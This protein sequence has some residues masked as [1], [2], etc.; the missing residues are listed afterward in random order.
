MFTVTPRTEVA[1]SEITLDK[2]EQYNLAYD[3]ANYFH[4]DV[5][6]WE[7][8]NQEFKVYAEFFQ[9]NF[10]LSRLVTKEGKLA[11]RIS[12]FY[13]TNYDIVLPDTVMTGIGNIVAHHSP[14][15]FIYDVT[16]TFDW[17]AGDFGDKGSCFWGNRSEAKHIIADA[18]GLALR[19]FNDNGTGNG[20]CWLMPKDDKWV[21]F[22]AYG[23][24]LEL[25]GTRIGF[26]FPEA[27]V[28]R[29]DLENFGETGGTLYINN[30]GLLVSNYEVGHMWDSIDLEAGYN[31]RS[32]CD[33]CG[34]YYDD[35]G[36]YVAYIDSTICRSCRQDYR[37]CQFCNE[38]HHNSTVNHV[39]LRYRSGIWLSADSYLCDGCLEEAH[40]CDDCERYISSYYDPTTVQGGREVCPVC[41]RRYIKCNE[42]NEYHM[43]G[44]K[45]ECQGEDEEAVVAET[46]YDKLIAKLREMNVYR[47]YDE[48]NY[49]EK[50]WEATEKGHVLWIHRVSQWGHGVYVVDRARYPEILPDYIE[51]S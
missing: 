39:S 16:D 29:I 14:G 24:S 51:V 3:L 9:D 32:T 6:H 19:F 49:Q 25:I 27:K 41:L 2:D 1:S 31:D 38:L 15:G 13:K 4:G 42:C 47:E 12:K 21:A 33:H 43:N 20:R 46:L 36:Y 11:K 37:C 40:K 44:D 23:P 28:K 10:D 22:N 50:A 45:C 30:G 5:Y 34:E 17:R 35:D 26:I 7:C 18:G 8:R 48:E